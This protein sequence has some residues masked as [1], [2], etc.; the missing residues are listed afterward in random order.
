[1]HNHR[2]IEKNGGGVYIMNKGGEDEKC[3]KMSLTSQ[4]TVK[5]EGREGVQKVWND[6]RKEE[7]ALNTNYRNIYT[8]SSYQKF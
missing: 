2:I 6:K 7:K 8:R 5:G 3:K 1:M 4:Q